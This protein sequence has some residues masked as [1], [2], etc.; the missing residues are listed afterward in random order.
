MDLFL[1]LL[2]PKQNTRQAWFV[3]VLSAH[4]PSLLR[5]RETQIDNLRLMWDPKVI[6]S[7]GLDIMRYFFMWSLDLLFSNSPAIIAIGFF[8]FEIGGIGNNLQII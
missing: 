5:V 3:F 8:L 1:S 4:R 7:L 2:V 6:E